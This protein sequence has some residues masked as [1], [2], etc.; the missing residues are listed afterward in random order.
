MNEDNGNGRKSIED[1]A[2]DK[3]L[4]QFFPGATIRID[5]L[6]RR[7]GMIAESIDK[8]QN[9][10][11]SVIMT[12]ITAEQDDANYRQILKRGRWANQEH[13]DK[14]VKAL[15]VCRITGAKKAAQV[16][17]D[18]ITADSAGDDGVWIREATEALTHTT[19]TWDNNNRKAKEK[20]DNSPI[21]K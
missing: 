17:L 15:A 10:T 3:A 7:D 9:K 19:M 14:Y 13:R 8:A 12:M 18:L 6:V 1:M 2:Q 20:H 4:A 11:G 16:L 5:D 21:P